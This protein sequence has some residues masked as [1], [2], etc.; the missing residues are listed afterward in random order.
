MMKIIILIIVGVVHIRKRTSKLLC[1]DSFKSVF[2][3]LNTVKTRKFGRVLNLRRVSMKT[4]HRCRR[5]HGEEST[6]AVP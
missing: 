2:L 6:G 5:A 4:E 3:D 1:T